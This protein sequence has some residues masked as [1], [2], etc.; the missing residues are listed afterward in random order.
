VIF[1]EDKDSKIVI[2]TN[3]TTQQR[4][5][6][7]GQNGSDV[8]ISQQIVKRAVELHDIWSVK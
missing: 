8:Y 5:A 1:R 7:F 3:S 6:T 4:T 2:L